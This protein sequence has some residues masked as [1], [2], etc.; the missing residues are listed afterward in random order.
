VQM[1]FLSKLNT[2]LGLKTKMVMGAAFLVIVP[3]TCIGYI[4]CLKSSNAMEQVAITQ[5][6]RIVHGLAQSVERFLKEQTHIARGLASGYSSFGGMDI[7]FYGGMGID[8]LT[9]KRVNA[10][11]LKNLESLGAVYE[12]VFFGDVKGALFAGV[13]ASGETPYKG[14]TIAEMTWFASSRENGTVSVGDIQTSP[15]TG[16][17]VI[18]ICAPVFDKRNQFAAVLGLELKLEAVGALV[19]GIRVG[20]RGYAFMI[21]GQGLILAH[22]DAE[23]QL[24]LNIRNIP[25][26]EGISRAMLAGET[27]VSGYI[28]KDKNKVAG[29][30]PVKMNN[31]SV[32]VTQERDEFMAVAHQIRDDNL[33]FGG[34]FTAVT[35]VI[36][37]FLASTISGPVKKTV[38]QIQGEAD[39][40]VVASREFESSS[41]ILAKGACSQT[42]SL[43]NTRQS[44]AQMTATI[45]RNTNDATHADE[46][47]QSTNAIVDTARQKMAVLTQSIEH[48]AAASEKTQKIV[49]SIDDI[50]FQTNILALN[51][52]VEAARAGEAGAAFSVVADEVRS[53][54]GRT[55]ESARETSMLIEETAVRINE[56]G[57]VV[58]Q[59]QNT[60]KEV[61]SSANQVG[62]LLKGISETSLIQANDV[63][64]VNLEVEQMSEVVHQNA[65]A[66]EESASASELLRKQ[67]FQ[68]QQMLGNMAELVVGKVEQKR[69]HH[70]TTNV[71]EE[72]LD[73]NHLSMSKCGE[74]SSLPNHQQ[75]M[76]NQVPVIEGLYPAVIT[77]PR[78]EVDF[79]KAG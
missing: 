64:K 14:N 23:H 37:F 60:F 50:A 19:S 26:M 24:T 5:S 2:R 10:S 12:G 43:E 9:E 72:R 71:A 25:G 48:I 77:T 63:E 39:H 45:H 44:L 52:A 4:T 41:H 18:T 49:K 66:A 11:L 46:L 20:N 1:P 75:F 58:N 68:M 3:L 17:P 67:A 62:Q 70:P 57:K 65:S 69:L 61:I 55:A 36:A 76:S 40:I 73:S 47:M 29:F 30:T 42:V 28:F 79:L 27:G 59:A 15:I 53:L 6:Q 33:L 13:T 34:G 35:I 38:M 54:A 22:P 31:W 21:D 8:E 16:N 32:A 51:A 74:K 7:Q 78:N 56:G